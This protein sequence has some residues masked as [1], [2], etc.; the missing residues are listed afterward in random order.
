MLNEF[1]IIQLNK[2]THAVRASQA[3]L[4]YGVGAMVDFPEQTL[5]TAA[6]ETWDGSVV[7][8]HD[9]RLEKALH[10]DFFGMPGSK[11]DTRYQ[12]GIAYSRFPEWYFCPRCRSFKP[13]KEW[14]NEYNSN[15]KCKKMRE[16]DPYM[17]KNLKCPSC[18]Q[19]LVVARIVVACGHGHIDDFPW[20]K[21]VHAKNGLGAKKICYNPKLRFTTSASSTEG[22]EGL[23]ITCETC[24][25]RATLK[26]AFDKN[27]LENL[28]KATGY[29]YGFKCTGRH[30]WKNTTEMCGKYPHVLQRGGSSVYFPIVVSSL[31]IPPYSSQLTAKIQGSPFFSDLKKAITESIKTVTS[32][33]MELTQE[34][35]EN[36]V[37]Q[38][39]SEY[40]SKIG[41]DIGHE[42]ASEKPVL[43]RRWSGSTEDS[44]TTTS[45]KYR[46]E[47]YEALSGEVVQED[48]NGEFVR[49]S[50]DIKQYGLPYVK[51]VSLI[52]KV[53]E[54]QA[55][56][57][58]SRLE[59]VEEDNVDNTTK[60]K[61]VSIK[62]ED[63]NWYPGYDVRGE[64]IFIELNDDAIDKWRTNNPRIQH[65]VDQL[66]EN[67][68]KSYYGDIRP[69]TITAKFLLLHTLS[70][71]L[72]KQLSFECG[73]S[74]A[75]I[76]ERIY[77]SESSEGK[78]MSGILIYTASGDS[79]G[80]MG[81]LVRQGRYDIFPSIFKKAIEGAIT[82]S[83]DPVCS[84]SM[85]QGRDSLNLSACH[86]CTLVPETSCEEFNVFLDRGMIIGT[87]EERNIG[88]FSEYIYKNAEI[89][90]IVKN[91]KNDSSKSQ[92]IITDSG[93]NLKNTDYVDVWKNI[94]Q[95]SSNKHEREIIN[96]LIDKIFD[97]KDG[98]K[99]FQ[100]GTFQVLGDP[101][102]YN[103]DLYWPN[104]K[105]MIFS[106]ENEEEFDK[107]SR[108]E[109]K[110]FCLSGEG[111]IADS[112]LAV[113]KEI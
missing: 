55:L 51:K 110:C 59:P 31:V 60:I 71:L 64:G 67:Y 87:Y 2:I 50:T 99:P 65:R 1:E 24:H 44:Y 37:S 88:F 96:E 19:E 93:T 101:N 61:K 14:I 92:I 32:L 94:L 69:R 34:I 84:L 109:W 107:A 23:T 17:T 70:H 25:A 89:C 98:E 13:L 76:K 4:Q 26:G 46:A 97:Y 10:V 80:T 16:N 6:P 48:K 63:T 15:P 113:L 41:R 35:R 72:M 29:E 79:E 111:A 57:G 81:G 8:V 105:V 73:Y 42:E 18:F 58:F 108:S 104:K 112:V 62:E 54:V 66:N 36:I 103:V 56:V 28:D 90:N 83:N 39:I 78:S 74:I 27:A 20:I 33:G 95:F 47:E 7:E 102:Y 86:A 5:M 106:A 40:A 30:P 68:S 52:H 85:G 3:V 38:K 91:S 49:E 75:S 11:D 21:W 100:A 45:V 53:R 12:K 43:I 82:C 22:L 9:E 77:C